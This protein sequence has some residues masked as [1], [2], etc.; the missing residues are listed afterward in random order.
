MKKNPFLRWKRLIKCRSFFHVMSLTL[1]L[2]LG[3]LSGY[4]AKAVR[5]TISLNLQEVKLERF[6]EVM[7]QKTGLNFLYN[8]LLFKDAKPVSVTANGENW[9]TVLKRVLDKEGFTY[10]VKDEIVVI[11]RKAETTDEKFV[12]VKG[13]VIDSRKEPLPGVTVLLKGMTIGTVTDV[14]GEFSIRVPQGVDSLIVSFI[15]MQTEYLKLEKDKLEYTI[16]MKEDV[17]RL[18]E[19]VVTGYQE[20]DKTRMAG[21]VSSIKAED[22]YFSGTNT[23]E[24]ALQGRLPGVVI[25]N[26]SGLVGVRQKTRVRGTSTLL[27]SQEPVWVVD[28]IIQEDPLPFDTQTF[29]SMGEINS[30]NFD[31]I[32][33]FVGSSISW[34]NPNDI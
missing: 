11:K 13:K 15:G 20:F 2:T 7:K 18:G 4:G 10:D 23:L 5:D 24:Q 16:V 12:I 32:R 8:S 6:V 22:L 33:N 21:S 9:E 3:S 27:G 29:N 19:V 28:G 31:Y 1:V 30:D 17:M 34:L 25:T 26:T 14:K